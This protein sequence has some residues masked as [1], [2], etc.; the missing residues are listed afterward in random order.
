MSHHVKL[1]TL[2]KWFSEP[3]TGRAFNCA[4]C[5]RFIPWLDFHLDGKAV[6]DYY[7]PYVDF[8]YSL[9]PPEPEMVNWC[10]RCSHECYWIPQLRKRLKRKWKQS[11]TLKNG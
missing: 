7:M 4:G 5:G 6:T 9:D 10:R 2:L 1:T 8:Y 11:R 3:G